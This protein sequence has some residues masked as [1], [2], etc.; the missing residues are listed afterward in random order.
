V[1]NDT[2]GPAKGRPPATKP[3]GGSVIKRLAP[4]V[5]GT[6]RLQERYRDT[7]VCVRYRQDDTRGLRYTTVELVVDQRPFTVKEDLI[8][9]R[10]FTVFLR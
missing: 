2:T 1:P 9:P 4:G 10:L 3:P 5:P 6:R 8:R 7:L